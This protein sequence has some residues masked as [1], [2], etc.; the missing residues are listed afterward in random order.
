MGPRSGDDEE[1]RGNRE[2]TERRQGK[3]GMCR[4]L[5]FG[6]LAEEAGC[7]KGGK[8]VRGAAKRKPTSRETKER[9]GGDSDGQCGSGRLQ[10][11][12]PPWER[13]CKLA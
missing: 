8:L 10:R 6:M 3:R 7:R 1:E 11:R 9:G 2:T 13:C 5:G 12:G 4:Q